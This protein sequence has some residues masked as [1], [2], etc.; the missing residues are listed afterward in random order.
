VYYG[1]GGSIYRVDGPGGADT[2]L[3]AQAVVGIDVKGSFYAEGRYCVLTDL[4]EEEVGAG[5][6]DGIRVMAGY[7]WNF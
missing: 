5:D 6:I 7:R 2:T 4:D 1:V 3:G